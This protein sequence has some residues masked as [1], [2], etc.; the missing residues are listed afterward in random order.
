M[1]LNFL[2]LMIVQ[3]V[4]RFRSQKEQ[5]GKKLMKFSDSLNAFR[6]SNKS[7]KFNYVP[8]SIEKEKER[9]KD[10]IKIPRHKSA[11]PV[12]RTDFHPS[13]H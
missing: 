1:T 2:S 11:F 4:E 6:L 10:L 9:E 3:S 8:F 13:M 5:R 12:K 7:Y